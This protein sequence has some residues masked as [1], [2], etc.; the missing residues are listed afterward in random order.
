MSGEK[1]LSC[2]CGAVE[3]T[4]R[5]AD[6]LFGARRCNC[7]FCRRRGAV[8]VTAAPGGIEVTRGAD[9]LTLYQWGSLS[10]QH[11]FCRT[12]GIYTHHRR[13]G[14]SEEWAVNMGALED[15]DPSDHGPFP[16]FPGRDVPL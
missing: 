7:S 1:R 15:V 11:Y 12:C 16:W 9:N 14:D 10:A 4:V 3:L 6:G 8:T 5:L 2:H 13:R